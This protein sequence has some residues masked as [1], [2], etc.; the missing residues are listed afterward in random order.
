MLEEIKENYKKC[1]SLIEGWQSLS[2]NEL[3]N[4]YVKNIDNESLRASYF[5]AL[6]LKYWGIIGKYYKQSKAS[7]VT[8]EECYDWLC[9]A[10][11]YTL[12][13]HIWTDPNNEYYNDESAPDK[14]IN[15]KI[16]SRRLQY[17]KQSNGLNRAVYQYQV[18]FTDYLNQISEDMR[19]A[20]DTILPTG[21]HEDFES[22][23]KSQQNCDSIIQYYLDKGDT[24]KALVVKSI[25]NSNAVNSSKVDSKEILN[26]ILRQKTLESM[27]EEYV[28]DNTKL[29]IAYNK[30]KTAPK[31]RVTKYIR[32]T[33]K[34]LRD[35]T[36]NLLLNY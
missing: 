36:Y 26:Y 27:R 34:D 28:V 24:I 6:M 3:A 10:L 29:L 21:L 8:I 2:K 23:V 12:D 19:N 30:F 31:K 5:S 33:L 1:A 35:K 18:F 11:L 32:E 25:C 16:K 13:R 14:M 15:R 7:K 4:L 20:D 17:Y 9:D 22:E